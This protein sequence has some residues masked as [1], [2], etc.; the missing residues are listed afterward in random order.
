ML[1][2]NDLPVIE[3]ATYLGTDTAYDI[4]VGEGVVISVRDQNAEAGMGRFSAGENVKLS[5]SDGAARML[6]D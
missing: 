4:N 6:V 2:S 3:A 1:K 5:F